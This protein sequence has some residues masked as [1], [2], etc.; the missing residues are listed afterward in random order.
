MRCGNCRKQIDS[1]SSFCIYCGAKQPEMKLSGICPSCGKKQDAEN[2][3]C[4]N[5]GCSLTVVK[6]RHHRKKPAIVYAGAVLAV[7]L[8]I[9]GI[10][11]I[12]SNKNGKPEQ[13]QNAGIAETIPESNTTSPVDEVPVT[14]DEHGTEVTASELIDQKY[15]E[16]LKSTSENTDRAALLSEWAKE[17]YSVNL[18]EN[19]VLDGE[20][21]SLLI[22][23]LLTSDV[24]FIDPLTLDDGELFSSAVLYYLNPHSTDVL[25]NKYGYA[26]VRHDDTYGECL[27]VMADTINEMIRGVYGVTMKHPETSPRRPDQCV[28][29]LYCMDVGDHGETGIDSIRGIKLEEDVFL[30]IASEYDP[31]S[32][33]TTKDTGAMVARRNSE[34]PFGFNVIARAGR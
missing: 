32:E 10:K 25:V 5:C 30:V 11:F 16:Q 20:L 17:R 1:G 3:Y 19:I 4:W 14:M 28:D 24:D 21:E 12:S 13:A 2:E 34:S 9:Y 7:I 22:L 8:L 29:G 26:Y 15:R 27:Y 6:D 18:T 23:Y 33:E 31:A